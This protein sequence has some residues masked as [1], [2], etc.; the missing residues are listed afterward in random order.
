MTIEEFGKRVKEKIAGEL[1]Q[2][3]RVSLRRVRKNNGV[4]RWGIM[5]RSETCNVSPT[6]YIENFFERYEKGET[7]R[8]VVDEIRNI[9]KA[10]K[11]ETDLGLDF[12]KDAE[13][14][15]ERI[16]FR[17]I[18]KEKNAAILK[19][20]PYV[21]FLDLAVCFCCFCEDPE[22]GWGM[23]PIYSKH[24]RLW[25]MTTEQMLECA[26]VNTPKLL[27]S[28]CKRMEEL[29]KELGKGG[30][31]ESKD[32]SDDRE[33]AAYGDEGGLL[34]LSNCRRSYGAATILYPDYLKE[35]G[36]LWKSDFYILPSSVHE[37]ILLPGQACAD[38]EGLCRMI[39]EINE[40]QVKPEERLSDSLY[41]Y[42][43]S[44]GEMTL[45][46]K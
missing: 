38:E 46:R 4:V 32:S 36:S 45:R 42:D 11:P 33:Q 21:D 25:G 10:E 27:E 9:W 15:K 3:E 29:L 19:E 34:V 43:R 12:F 22:L 31:D 8:S 16:I 14:V 13:K 17:L 7:L 41:H 37:V 20:M 6:I 24:Q 1:E 28:E 2:G 5:I 23:I 35:L 44:T 30:A 39:R 40:T 26:R 18:N